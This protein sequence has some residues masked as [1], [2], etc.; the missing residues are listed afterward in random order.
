MEVLKNFKV[1]DGRWEEFP[2]IKI[3]PGEDVYVGLPICKM[4]FQA[5]F[6]QPVVMMQDNIPTVIELEE[7]Q[8]KLAN[9]KRFYLIADDKGLLKEVEPKDAKI[10][11]RLP[12]DTKISELVQ[13]NGQILK[14]EVKD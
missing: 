4:D 1:L 7:L 5:T 10:T 9:T 3:L 6:K 8:H 11:I 13:I 12:K 2:Y 14:Q